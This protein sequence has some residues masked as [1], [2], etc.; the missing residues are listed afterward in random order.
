M[1]RPSSKL[2]SGPGPISR[3]KVIRPAVVA[4]DSSVGLLLQL[5]HLCSVR[6]RAR[7]MVMV[8]VR[9]T[10]TGKVMAKYRARARCRERA[11]DGDRNRLTSV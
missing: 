4:V 9:A 1:S 5:G 8:R 7:F 2:G 11:R 6:G 10:V 3:T